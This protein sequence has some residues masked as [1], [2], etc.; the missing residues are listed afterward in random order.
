MSTTELKVTWEEP[1]TFESF[2][3]LDYSITVYNSSEPNDSRTYTVTD[4]SKHITIDTETTACSLLRFNVTARNEIERSRIGTTSGGFPVGE[5]MQLLYLYQYYGDGD[6]ILNKISSV[7]VC[8][9]VGKHRPKN[10]IALEP[11]EKTSNP[12]SH[13]EK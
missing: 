4:R 9:G 12:D 13:R 10:T 6:A 1:F 2:P 8:L 7:S 5:F 3:I 11:N